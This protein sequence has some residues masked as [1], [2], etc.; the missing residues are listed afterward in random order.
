M[1][2]VGL[3][4]VI[5]FGKRILGTIALVL[6]ATVCAGGLFVPPLYRAFRSAGAWLGR[7]AGA[8]LTW[9]LLAPFFYLCFGLGGWLLRL[10][11]RDPLDRAF[12]REQATYWTPRKPIAGP[13]HFSRQY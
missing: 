11:G 13:E 2:A 5:L 8:A 10:L 4:L 1:T 12:D 7:A 3:V 9:L 6:A